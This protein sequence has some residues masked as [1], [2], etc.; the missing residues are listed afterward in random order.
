MLG[1]FSALNGRSTRYKTAFQ[2]GEGLEVGQSEFSSAPSK[3][4]DMGAETGWAHVPRLSSGHLKRRS[5]MV[6]TPCCGLV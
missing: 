1:G 5:K 3:K 2:A 4:D 6:C